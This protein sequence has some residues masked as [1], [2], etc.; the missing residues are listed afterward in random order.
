MSD[1]KLIM[2]SWRGYNSIDEQYDEALAYILESYDGLLTEGV[3][4]DIYKIEI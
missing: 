3:K 4:E 2:E 1:M